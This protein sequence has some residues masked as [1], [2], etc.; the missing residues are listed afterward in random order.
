MELTDSIRELWSELLGVEVEA[1][2]NFFTLG[3][4]SILLIEM[5]VRA[6]QMGLEIAPEQVLE[7]PTPA[8]LATAL[9]RPRT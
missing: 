5:V 7:Y 1:H 9:A 8:G 2:D 6:E 4:Y 3:G